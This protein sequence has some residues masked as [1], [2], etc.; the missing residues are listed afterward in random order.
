MI[1]C[2]IDSIMQLSV[3][4]NFVMFCSIVNKLVTPCF[5]YSFCTVSE[6]LSGRKALVTCLFVVLMD[7]GLMEQLKFLLVTSMY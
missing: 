2:C 7:I 5:C 4:S 6:I 3:C 1:Y